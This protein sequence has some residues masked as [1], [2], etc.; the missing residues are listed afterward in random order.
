MKRRWIVVLAVVATMFGMLPAVAAGRSGDAAAGAND[1]AQ[2]QAESGERSFEPLVAPETV[3]R[4]ALD[5]PMTLSGAESKIDTALSSATGPV[6][7][8]VRLRETPS[9]DGN[10]KQLA[11]IERQQARFLAKATAAGAVK[12][13]EVKRVLNAVFLEVDASQVVELAANPEVLSIKRVAD[14]QMDLSETVPYIGA[15]TVQGMDIDG[16]GVTVAV[17]DSGI[18]YTHADLGGPGTAMAYFQAYGENS[19]SGKNRKV[20]DR[21]NSELLFPTAKVVG[22]Y[23]F[24]GERWPF[25]ALRPDPD[26]I[27]FEGHGTHVA[28]IIGG[29]NGVA[30]GVELLAV[31]VC[32]A[33]STSCSGVA[34]IQGMDFAVENGVDIINMSLGS[35][36][37]QAFDDDL[38]TAVENATAAGVLTVAS[39]GNSSNKPYVTG[40]PAAA[41]S[42]LSVAQTQVPSAVEIPME[43]IQ[44]AESAGLY[45][46]V[47]QP[48]AK[49]QTDK[50]SGIVTYG[51]GSGGNLNGCAAFAPG[52]L[53]GQIVA[54]DRGACNFSLKIQNI[55]AAGGILGIIITVNGAAPFPGGFGGGALPQIPAYMILD[56]DGD[57]LRAGG[58]EV[59][60]DPAIGTPLVGTMVGSSA[61]GPSM[62]TNIVKPEIG[63]PGA[64]ISAEAG[65]GTGVTPFGGTSG[66]APMV[67]GSAAL[68]LAAEPSLAPAEVKARLINTGDTDISTGPGGTLAPITRI[69][70]GEV[71]VDRAVAS[72][73]AAWMPML[74]RAHCPSGSSTPPES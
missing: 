67:S 8:S 11:A 19:F 37:G 62:L 58:A 16:T 68:L 49:P 41:P 7:I 13:G 65:T 48:W 56:T 52:S 73:A 5:Q 60:F 14:Y 43:I 10:A 1:T 64:S 71:R 50:I 59:S 69:G 42:A 12:L 27:D 36:Y 70:G 57:P 44:P 54:V 31:K 51:D 23:D 32:S 22:G 26:P 28:D 63:A 61:R 30:P 46:A 2:P 53:T 17:L 33:V 18:D 15:S 74:S 35:I 21:Y 72:D 25:G 47:F 20:T 45:E 34:L 3:Q 39:A 38:S 29:R 9:P 40:A 66:A 4:L 24:V 55:E 6:S